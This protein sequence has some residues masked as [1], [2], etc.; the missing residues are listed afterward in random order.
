MASV[1]TPAFTAAIDGAV[2]PAL[3]WIVVFWVWW[4]RAQSA[5]QLSD[6]VAFTGAIMDAMLRRT[7]W[8]SYQPGR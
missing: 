3:K 6:P 1:F 7:Y 5:P 8:R 2:T 4:G